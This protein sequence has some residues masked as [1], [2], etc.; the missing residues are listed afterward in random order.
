MWLGTE[1]GS[2]GVSEFKGFKGAV[3]LLILKTFGHMIY[4]PRRLGKR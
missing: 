3:S 2:A 4:T 1:A